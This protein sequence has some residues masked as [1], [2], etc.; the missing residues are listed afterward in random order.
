MKY[1]LLFVTLF[2]SACSMTAGG[3]MTTTT[4]VNPT[5]DTKFNN[6]GQQ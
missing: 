3:D 5:V 2:I 1:L 6:V 4:T